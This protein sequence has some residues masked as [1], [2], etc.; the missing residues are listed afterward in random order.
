MANG[1]ERENIVLGYT[2]IVVKGAGRFVTAWY[3]AGKEASWNRTIQRDNKE[4]SNKTEEIPNEDKKERKSRGSER[5]K[6]QRDTDIA[7]ENSKRREM[8]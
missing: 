7:V 1:R 3:K 8:E 6:F 4:E 5:P 2:G